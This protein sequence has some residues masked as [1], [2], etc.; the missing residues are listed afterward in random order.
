MN[1]MDHT[2][3]R[4]TYMLTPKWCVD[5]TFTRGDGKWGGSW[6][7]DPQRRRVAFLVIVQIQFVSVLE[8]SAARAG[9]V[10][11]YRCLDSLLLVYAFNY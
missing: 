7:L 2:E 9:C 5:Q 3:Y 11:L 6:G 8:G 4:P 1:L 10:R